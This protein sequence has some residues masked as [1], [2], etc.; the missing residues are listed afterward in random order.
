VGA[1]YHHSSQLQINDGASVNPTG[2]FR[3][4]TIQVIDAYAGSIVA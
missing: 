2:R 3:A 4:S 1:K